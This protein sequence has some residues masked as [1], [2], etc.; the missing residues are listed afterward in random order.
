MFQNLP[1]VGGAPSP[2]L[3][4]FASLLPPPPPLT[5][6][7]YTTVTGIAKGHKGP[8]PPPPPLIGEYKKWKKGVGGWYIPLIDLLIYFDATI[9]ITYTPN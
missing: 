2:P 4:R 3:G 5:N 1:T 9:H 6:P 7:S 8:P